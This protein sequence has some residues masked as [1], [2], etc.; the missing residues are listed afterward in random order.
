MAASIADTCN[1]YEGEMMVPEQP[2]QQPEGLTSVVC[3]EEC[4]VRSQK[5]DHTL[6]RERVSGGHPSWRMFSRHENAEPL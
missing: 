5:H 4:C 6:V 1:E 2:A 3:V